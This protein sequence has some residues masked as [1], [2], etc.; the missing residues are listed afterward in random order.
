LDDWDRERTEST[1]RLLW[2]LHEDDAAGDE[3]A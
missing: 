2:L 1:E 3:T